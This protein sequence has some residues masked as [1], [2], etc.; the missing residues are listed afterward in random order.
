VERTTFRVEREV[1]ILHLLPDMD[2]LEIGL[3][4]WSRSLRAFEPRSVWGPGSSWRPTT[5]RSKAS[6]G[7]GRCPSQEARSD[8][9][10]DLARLAK[11]GSSTAG[12]HQLSEEFSA[13]SPVEYTLE[14]SRSGGKALAAL[15]S[16][17]SLGKS[18]YQTLLGRLIEN[19]VEFKGGSR[20]MRRYVLDVVRASASGFPKSATGVVGLSTGVAAAPCELRSPGTSLRGGSRRMIPGS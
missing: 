11:G 19:T 2:A 7:R 1:D 15:A 4:S 18:G 13:E 6:T 20:E 12:M 10:A 16:L 9:R 14:T 17:H 3:G 8:N 5:V